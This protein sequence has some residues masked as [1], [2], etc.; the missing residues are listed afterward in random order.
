M[1]KNILKYAN[2]ATTRINEITQLLTGSTD[3][4]DGLLWDIY[5]CVFDMVQEY[6]SSIVGEKI[7]HDDF[8]NMITEIMYAEK[9]EIDNII[10]KYSI[11]F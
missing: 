8:A 7:D 2:E 11:I 1:N 9:G 4:S 10:K 5:C 3:L 6:I